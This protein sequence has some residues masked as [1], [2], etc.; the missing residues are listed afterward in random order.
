[1]NITCTGAWR[2]ALSRVTRLMAARLGHPANRMAAMLLPLALALALAGGPAVAVQGSA[3]VGLPTSSSGGEGQ[4]F[5]GGVAGSTG[6]AGGLV[7]LPNGKYTEYT[8][9]LRVKVPGGYVRWVRDFNGNQWRFNPQWSSL[10]FEFDEVQLMAASSGGGGGGGGGSSAALAVPQSP[11]EVFGGTTVPG[12]SGGLGPSGRTGP[13]WAISRNGAWFMV[14]ASWCSFTIQNS[15]RYLLKPVFA[16][17][18]PACPTNRF[19][20]QPRLVGGGSSGGGGGG[21]GSS[22]A[23]AAIR[24]DAVSGGIP[25]SVAG[26]RWEDRTGDW[27]EYDRSG[28]ITAYGDRNNIR[29]TMQYSGGVLAGV[30]DHTGRQVLSFSYQGGRLQSVRDVPAP[31]DPDPARQVSY[32]YHD[33]GSIATVTDVR[34]NVT[35]YGYD[36]KNRL[37]TITDAEQRVR[38]LEYGPTNRVTKLTQPDGAVTDYD[39][40]Y[41]KTKQ[42]FL[43]RTLHPQVNG[44]R[45]VEVTLYNTDGQLIQQEINNRVQRELSQNGRTDRIT[46]GRGNVTEVLRNEFYQVTSVRHADGTSLANQFDARNMTLKEQRDRNGFTHRYEYDEAGNLRRRTLAAGTADERVTVYTRDARMRVRTVTWKGRTEVNGLVTPDASIS[47]EYDDQDNITSVTDAE[48]KTTRYTH[49]RLGQVLIATEPRGTTWSYTYDADGNQ[50]TVRSPLGF[51]SSTEYDRVGN[52]VKFTDG[53][54]KVWRSDY[55]GRD[56]QVRS[57]NPY[58]DQYTTQYNGMGAVASATDASGKTTSVEYDAWTRPALARDGKGYQYAMDY[59]E[60]DGRDTGARQPNRLKYPTF[61]RL[62]R[63]DARNRPSQQT[64]LDGTDGRTEHYTYDGE[65]RRKTVTDANGKTRSLDYNAY[66]Q[67]VRM[68][69]SMGNAM[70]LLYDARGSVIEIADPNG[71]KT[72]FEYDL[73]GLM[74]RETDPLGKSILYSYDDNGWARDI[75]FPSGNRLD[76]THDDDGRLVTLRESAGGRLVKTTAFTYDEEDN[77]RSWSDGSFGATLEYDDAERLS[78]ETVHYGA[79]DRS[80]GYTYY[81]NGQVKTYTGP[82]GVTISY[83]YDALGQLERVSIPGEGEMAVTEWQWAAR[84]KV[85]LP[86]GTEQRL[87]H[88]GLLM[89]TKL[90]VVNPG[91]A[92][93]FELENKYGRLHEV[94]Q[95]KRD[96]A[97][98]TYSYDDAYRL[99]GVQA[100][101]S[102]FSEGYTVNASGD[103]VGH[104]RT[105]GATWQYDAAGQLKQRGDV[106]YEYDDNGNL[107]KKTDATRAEPQRTITYA[108]DPLN[109]LSEVRDGAGSLLARYS[110]DPFDRRLSKQLGDG[111][112][113]YYLPSPD[114]LLAELDAAGEVQ[115]VYGWH[116]EHDNGTYPLYARINDGQDGHRYVYYHNDH[117]GTPQRIT[118][119]AGKLV[120]AAQYDGFGLATVSLPPEGGVTNPLRYP[121]QYFDAESGLHYND[122]RYYDPQTGRY[123]TR[124]P[125]GFAGGV[126]LYAYAAHSPTNLTDPTG[127][128]LPCLAFNYLRC[129]ATCMALSTA[130]DYLLE[131]GNIDWGGN[132]KDCAVECLWGML[133]IPDPCGKFGKWFGMGMGAAGAF[134]SFASDTL[135]HAMPEGA[136]LQD[137]Q[138]GRALLKPIGE[139]R[140]GDKVLALSEW[141]RRSAASGIDDR[142]SYEQVTDV[143]TSLREQVLVHITL[144][145]GET[146]TATEGHPFLTSDGWRDAVLLKKGGQLLLKGGAPERSTQA[147]KVE[148]RSAAIADVRLETRAVHVFNLEVANAHTFFVGVEGL[149]VHN[150]K[151]RTSGENTHAQG[152]R[153]FHDPN[154]HPYPPGYNHEQPIPGAGRAD[155]VNDQTQR[156]RERKYTDSPKTVNRAINQV[157]RYCKKKPGYRGEVEIMSPSTGDITIFSVL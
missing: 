1:M 69:D 54:G 66:G 101:N 5:R 92:T 86:G 135:V 30:R 125:L 50:L 3:V 2:S 149:V 118:D 99:T 108:Y 117:L 33:S 41:D 32:T 147:G 138:S 88:D 132:A 49:N 55:D 20:H 68:A 89:L 59:T 119:K 44:Q 157:K 12:A 95:A 61:D 75:T 130:E 4:H 51:A 21:G 46:D 63:Y 47:F 28:R 106:I 25:D 129:M 62:W 34:G 137:G 79:F 96:G 110:Y 156:I 111:S 87:E 53:R 73:R 141:K 57:V 104:T 116:P 128:I 123:I 58:G 85:L 22:G 60:P 102:A 131:C 13:L 103:R 39:Y 67:L 150:A 77:L 56:R 76:Y 113:T 109:R 23:A 40:D 9:D 153:D 29:V 16:G 72:K 81:P 142:L 65:G 31:G 93:V 91:Q 71:R 26:F 15:G 97:A 19:S 52:E 78:R 43:A 80:R 42:Q 144:A 146:I 83:G 94:Q 98:V 145:S 134:N 148:E 127:E 6:V 11:P 120:W 38:A 140:P 14:D 10:Q 45:R 17:E 37:T 152:G 84:K 74:I 124:D 7:W 139:L 112:V 64:D 48:G 154:K 36:G 107:T 35:R 121:G 100:D 143:F 114:G 70:R 122:R 18:A 126:N 105:G 155:A 151:S 115:V 8:E 82:D 133:P 136:T 27:I 24:L 90:T